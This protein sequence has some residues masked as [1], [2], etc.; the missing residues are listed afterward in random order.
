MYSLV[1]FILAAAALI[2]GLVGLLAHE[3]L[4]TWA[5][6]HYSK[7]EKSFTVVMLIIYGVGVLAL[8]WYATIFDYVKYGWILTAFITLASIKLVG[9]IFKW[10]ETSRKFV[11]FIR[12]R[13]MKL[14]LLD[15]VVTTLGIG[16]LLAGLYVY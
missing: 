10:E 11:E 4:Y 3:Q 15:I 5:E 1:C 6:A 7:E 8:T 12:G 13:G 16:F 14:K 2:K 9:I